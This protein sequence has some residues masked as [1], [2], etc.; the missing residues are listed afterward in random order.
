MSHPLRRCLKLNITGPEP[1]LAKFPVL[2]VFPLLVNNSVIFPNIWLRNQVHSGFSLHLHSVLQLITNLYWIWSHLTSKV[3]SF[4]H[5]TGYHYH[6]LVLLQKISTWSL[7]PL[8][9]SPQKHLL[10]GHQ[11]HFSKKKLDKLPSGSSLSSQEKVLAWPPFLVL[12]IHHVSSPFATLN[13]LQPGPHSF[14]PGVLSDCG[15]S[16]PLI[17]LRGSH[18]FLSKP[19]HVLCLSKRKSAKN[20]KPPFCVSS[21]SHVHVSI[22]TAVTFFVCLE[23]RYLYL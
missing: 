12:F 4:L 1:F 6:L 8:C 20:P 7:C 5:V 16:S 3:S 2:P 17:C 10:C 14:S 19:S 11:S 13:Y 22:I 18:L 9:D 23:S 21:T 15:S